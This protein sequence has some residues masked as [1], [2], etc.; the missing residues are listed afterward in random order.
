[1][2]RKRA[3]EPPTLVEYGS[4]SDC[5]LGRAGG[6]EGEPSEGCPPKDFNVCQTDKFGEFSCS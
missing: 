1:M 2:D 4:I 6:C 5:T 3:Y